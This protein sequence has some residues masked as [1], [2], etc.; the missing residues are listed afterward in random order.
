MNALLLRLIRRTIMNNIRNR[1][2]LLYGT[3]S[4]IVRQD[5]FMSL[6]T[7]RLSI[8]NLI[9]SSK[10]ITYANASALFTTTRRNI[11]RTRTANTYRRTSLKIYNRLIRV[12]RNQ[13][14][15]RNGR[16]YE[17]THL[18]SNNV[19]HLRTINERPLY[20]KIRIRRRNI[21]TY[22]RTSNIISSNLN[23]INNKNSKTSR[24]GKYMLFRR[25]THIATLNFNNRTFKTEN[26]ISSNRVF[27]RLIL[28]TTRTN[29][30]RSLITPL[31]RV[32]TN[33]T[34]SNFGSTL[35]IL[36]LMINH[37]I[38]LN[39]PY[40]LRYII[41]ILRRTTITYYA[42]KYDNVNYENNTYLYATRA[43]G[44][45]LS[46]HFGFLQA[47]V[48]NFHSFPWESCPLSRAGLFIVRDSSTSNK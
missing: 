27:F 25:R 5:T 44:R 30:F 39:F 37:P 16:I 13:L 21:T 12:L 23:K 3:R 20:T 29:L 1:R 46:S 40:D 43:N 42:T 47:S 17:T 4:I 2:F 10:Q 8:Y 22:S 24:A 19:R 11:R 33:A 9:R 32:Y 14:A 45:L 36:S 28:V 31:L 48:R 26:L 35:T 6:T 15:N 41:C 18:S 38:T 7:Y 34:T